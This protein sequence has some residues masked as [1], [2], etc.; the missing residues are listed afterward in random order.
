MASRRV[1][2][3]IPEEIREQ[4]LK[5]RSS[6]V[7]I[8][9]Q[10]LNDARNSGEIKSDT[11]LTLARL[12]ILGALNWSAEWFEASGRSLVDVA[13][14]FSG[15]VLEGLIAADPA[16]AAGARAKSSNKNKIIVPDL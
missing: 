13:R 15:L 11:D 16:A 3:Q 5:L 10:I 2:G 1:L 8:W 9:H 14:S 12:F 7:A 4:N 6:Y